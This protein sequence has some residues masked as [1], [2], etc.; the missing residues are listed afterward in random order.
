MP[1]LNQQKGF[2][3]TWKGGKEGTK[4]EIERKSLL[5]GDRA[6]EREREHVFNDVVSNLLLIK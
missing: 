3:E 6:V 1:F 5:K 2:I 4:L